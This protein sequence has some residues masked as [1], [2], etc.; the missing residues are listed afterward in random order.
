M[1]LALTVPLND[2]PEQIQGWSMMCGFQEPSFRDWSDFA[3]FVDDS[4]GNTVQHIRHVHKGRNIMTLPG[5]KKKGLRM[6]S[7]QG[8]KQS[9]MEPCRSEPILHTIHWMR[10]SVPI[11]DFSRPPSRPQSQPVQALINSA[12]GGPPNS[13]QGERERPGTCPTTSSRKPSKGRIGSKEQRVEQKKLTPMP[14]VHS[15]RHRHTLGKTLLET[16]PPIEG[17]DMSE[18]KTQSGT[19]AKG[20][21]LFQLAHELRIPAE[22]AAQA[23]ELFGR[24]SDGEGS[25]LFQRRLR[26]INVPALLCEVTHVNNLSDLSPHFVETATRSLNRLNAES[27][28][29]RE[30]FIWYS[31]FSFSEELTPNKEDHRTRRLAKKLGLE[32]VDVD[33]YRKAFD[34]FDTD[35]SGA[36]E[37][38]EF[39]E[40]LK[41]LLKLPEDTE[42]EPN[43]VANLFLMAD[44]NHDGEV[45][46]EEFCVFW[47]QSYGSGDSNQ[48]LENL[49]ASVYRSL[50]RVPTAFV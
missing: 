37:I 42:L 18:S 2:A 47:S 23:A 26:T 31:A 46:F 28:D 50:R 3:K 9:N 25:D 21:Q 27:I 32:V 1:V 41:D 38:D 43:R 11:S 4:A 36:I 6:S 5:L 12:R 16:L 19:N 45:D 10:G 29:V 48:G 44:T 15:P 17:L 49:F 13:E 7:R 22:L 40:I 39:Q 20:P 24:Y 33:D 14:A 34:K 8:S 35:G 30:F